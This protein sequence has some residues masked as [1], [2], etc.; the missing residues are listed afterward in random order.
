MDDLSGQLRLEGDAA[1]RGKLRLA[2]DAH[3]DT[4]QRILDLGERFCDGASTAEVSLVKA[5]KGG[6]GAQFF[7][8]WV[9]PTVFPGENAWPRA[10][11]LV[12]AMAA[13]IAGAPESLALARTGADI[14]AI[15]ERGGFAVLYGVEGAHALGADGEP[16]PTRHARLVELAAA[17]I[18][19]LACTWSN[20]NDFAGSSGDAGRARGLSP[21]GHDLVQ[22]CVELGVLL[23]VSHVSDA[24]FR[25]LA[26]WAAS[27][28]VPLIA[29]HSSARALT[30]HPRNLTDSQLATIADTGGVASVNFCPAFL[31]ET[32]RAEVTAATASPE[33]RAAQEV[34]RR[35]ESDAG[36][37]ALRAWHARTAF[38]RAV[39]A[40]GVDRLV[41]HVCHMI[42]VAGE[43]HV[44]LGSDFDGIAAVP[45]G[46]EDVSLLP[47][48]AD[49]LAD[50]R[51][52]GRI[53]DKIFAT[54][55]L[56]VLDSV[57]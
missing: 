30:A 4:A 12:A 48:L 33:A 44:G 3:A 49:G 53:I 2:I 52:P 54:N 11:R 10:R 29:S 31:D 37:A 26:S 13:E 51:L 28:G 6:L 38:A 9:D 16:W 23:D 42:S 34:A 19:Y 8:I 27:I 17:G 50:R 14:R 41:D 40:P 45:A 24:S 15:A 55:W 20:S 46:L 57:R 43:D 22:A 1:V 7:S 39:R 35:R 47:A 5:R 18:R 36:R 32:F 56:R 25:D 21:L